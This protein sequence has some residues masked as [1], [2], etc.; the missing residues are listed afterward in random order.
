[1]AGLSRNIQVKLTLSP[2]K[3]KG[4]ELLLALSQLPFVL[5]NPNSY[6]LLQE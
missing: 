3:M 5:K 4:R 2:R 6:V 1:M